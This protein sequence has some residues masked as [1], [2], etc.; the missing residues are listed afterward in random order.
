MEGIPNAST[1]EASESE[2]YPPALRLPFK[3]PISADIRKEGDGKSRGP[4]KL[5]AGILETDFETLYRKYRRRLRQ[6]QLAGSALLALTTIVFIQQSSNLATAREETKA[7]QA[8][9][10][11]Q[12]EISLRLKQ[13]HIGKTP[14]EKQLIEAIIDDNLPALKKLVTTKNQLEGLVG[15]SQ[16]SPL[17][18]AATSGST[19][20]IEWFIQQGIDPNA[21]AM[22]G[23][24]TAMMAAA[25]ANQV[26]S[27]QKLSSLGASSEGAAPPYGYRPIDYAAASGAIDAVKF[28]I[29]QGTAIENGSI[30][31]L[32]VAASEGHVNIV[33]YLLKNGANPQAKHLFGS[34][35][36]NSALCAPTLDAYE[37]ILKEL[38]ADPNEQRNRM[39]F[40]V[41]K[42]T[43]IDIEKAQQLLAEGADPNSV[44]TIQDLSGE[45]KLSLLQLL[46]TENKIGANT[47]AS[48]ENLNQAVRLLLE[49][50]A[51]P[52]TQFQH[53]FS[54]EK[55]TDAIYECVK[56]KS[57]SVETVLDFLERGADPNTPST[58][59][60]RTPL[61]LL[62]H[63]SDPTKKR[64]NSDESDAVRQARERL[65]KALSPVSSQ[66]RDYT[67]EK[68]R[69]IE[70][71][72]ALL[73]Y[74]A[75][76][77]YTVTK[78]HYSNKPKHFS[79]IELAKEKG[80]DEILDLLVTKESEIEIA[81]SNPS[82]QNT[83]EI[84]AALKEADFQFQNGNLQLPQSL[85]RVLPAIRSISLSFDLN[86]PA[87]S[88]YPQQGS[89]I[90]REDGAY[91]I[92]Y[93]PD[94]RQRM[95]TKTRLKTP[96]YWQSVHLVIELHD[97][98]KLTFDIQSAPNPFFGFRATFKPDSLTSDPEKAPALYVSYHK[99]NFHFETWHQGQLGTSQ[100]LYQK[101]IFRPQEKLLPS[102]II[103]V[104]LS[105]PD[106]SQK[107]TYHYSLD[108]IT[109]IKDAL[110]YLID[111][112][113]PNRE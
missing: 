82:S 77:E 9:T 63:L 27:L 19:N 111:T 71:A 94:F 14:F 31:S 98:R 65:D 43:S 80:M 13:T 53:K 40:G 86:S 61:T 21:R 57:Y 93:L 44:Q 56:N 47:G 96:F 34:T 66:K 15:S 72:K 104:E 29:E 12:R 67:A 112:D 99:N 46:M 97:G 58:K 11:A 85:L 26:N 42:K 32:G 113:Q 74:G 28:F 33:E 41:L 101:A 6:L 50:G 3:D 30:S 69:T 17:A 4:I 100:A 62:C 60:A 75:K 7:A 1:L 39:L 24:Q 20:A 22:K 109:E 16:I 81:Y 87:I 54:P 23:G 91:I 10:Q 108:N 2:C 89:S 8:E 73:K 79:L 38:S 76:T 55:N 48:P 45:R 102:S 59:F 5:L 52:N 64:R 18:L 84:I 88:F 103:K 107:K 83:K 68:Q 90:R 25:M 105:S 51:D 70:V 95:V 106:K 110:N 92:P 78:Y 36:L 35:I 37:L 49:F